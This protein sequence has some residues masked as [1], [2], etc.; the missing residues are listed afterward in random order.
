ML[1]FF[2]IFCSGDFIQYFFLNLRRIIAAERLN[3]VST[4]HFFSCNICYIHVSDGLIECSKR[5][6]DQYAINICDAFALCYVLHDARRRVVASLSLSL[7][8]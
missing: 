6:N 8:K 5:A 2:S 7:A 3:V 1:S 4:L